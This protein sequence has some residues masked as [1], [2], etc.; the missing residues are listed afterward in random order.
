MSAPAPDAATRPGTGAPGATSPAGPPG[1][2]PD[3]AA[4]VT[5]PTDAAA[6]PPSARRGPVGTV[7]HAVWAFFDLMGKDRVFG[8]AAETAFF[9]VVS[10]FPGLLI[11]ATTLSRLGAIVGTDVA[12]RVETEVVRRPAARARPRRPRAPSTR[13]ARCSRTTAATSSRSPWSPPSITVSGAFAAVLQALNIAYGVPETRSWLRRRVIG[14]LMAVASVVVAAV[15]LTVVVV[16]PL[17]G[18]GRALA[19]VVGG[20]AAVRHRLGRA[21]LA[22]RASWCWSRSPPR[23]ATSRPSMRTRWLADTPGG[24]LAAVLWLAASVRV[25]RLP[26]H[27]LR[28]EPAARRARWRH[29]PDDLDLPALPE[30]AARRRAQ[31]LD[32]PPPAP[33]PAPEALEVQ[34]PRRRP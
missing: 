19:E 9:T 25:Q 12:D 18:R 14:L 20:G 2:A 22:G 17:F 3:P 31:R 6:G 24:L 8:L 11:L 21:A 29:H 15:L 32:G 7:V 10:V 16:G 28:R 5:G 30:P 26:A 33:S 1:A 4:G 34:P 23:C 27:R 13:S